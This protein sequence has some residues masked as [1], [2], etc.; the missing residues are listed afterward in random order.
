[1]EITRREVRAIGWMIKYLPAELLQIF[2]R[3]AVCDHTPGTSDDEFRSE[4][5][6]V[7]SK[8]LYQIALQSRRVLE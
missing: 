7:H 2:D 3:R 5:C 8:T 1:M 6:C 4:L